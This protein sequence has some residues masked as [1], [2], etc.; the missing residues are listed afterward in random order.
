MGGSVTCSSEL[1]IGTEFKIKLS[2]PCYTNVYDPVVSDMK[3]YVLIEKP[4]GV[5][6]L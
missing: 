2:C 3:N 1:N 6:V 5:S 4:H